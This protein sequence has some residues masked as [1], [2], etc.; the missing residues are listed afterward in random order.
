MANMAIQKLGY[1]VL[2]FIAVLLR[3]PLVAQGPK[4]WASALF[5]DSFDVSSGKIPAIAQ[6]APRTTLNSREK[7][8]D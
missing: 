7:R 2:G 8:S 4:T 1:H 3:C 5:R 6:D